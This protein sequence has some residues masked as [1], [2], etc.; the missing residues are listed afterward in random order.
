MIGAWSEALERRD[1]GTWSHCNRVA[2]FA[3]ILAQAFGLGDEQ[4]R[5]IATGALLHEIGKLAIP[6]EILRK[7]AMLTREERLVMRESCSRGYEMLRSVPSLAE[8]AEIVYAH[9]EWFDGTGYPRAL[10]GEAIPLGARIVGVADAV[11]TLISDRPH[12]MAHAIAATRTE[13]L[14]WSGRQFDP[15]VVEVF[16]SVPDDAIETY[17]FS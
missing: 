1:P 17:L 3:T 2:A 10:K 7:P 15:H 11:E 14:R 13:V 12:H 4:I 8:A 5:V 6:E 9:R 16:M